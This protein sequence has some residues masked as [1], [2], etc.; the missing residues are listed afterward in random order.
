MRMLSL[1]RCAEGLLAL[2]LLAAAGPVHALMP[3]YVYE[4]ARNEAVSVIVLA[5]EAVSAIPPRFGDCTVAGTVAQVER[6]GAFAVGERVS[7]AVPCTQPDVQ[8]PIGGIIYRTVPQLQAAKYG[9]AYLDA[10]GKI[11]SSQYY[12]LDQLP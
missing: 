4:A 12:P 3:P 9:R 6:G 5:V 8:P 1:G 11:V 2:G 10:S 7:L